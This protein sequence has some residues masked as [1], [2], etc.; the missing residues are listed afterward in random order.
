MTLSGL[1]RSAIDDAST[2]LHTD[3]ETFCANYRGPDLVDGY[4]GF[5]AMLEH[6]RIPWPGNEDSSLNGLTLAQFYL[7]WAWSTNDVA[8]YCLGGQAVAQGWDLDHA[9][10]FGTV[11]AVSAAKLI[12]HAKLLMAI[13]DNRI[14]QESVE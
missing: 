8:K 3:Y 7:V 5:I 12:S 9:I 1:S 6:W 14:A 10:G 13:G 2:E 11:A 4:M